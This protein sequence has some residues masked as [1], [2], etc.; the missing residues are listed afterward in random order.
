MM[1]DRLT[2]DTVL[3]QYPVNEG[4]GFNSLIDVLKMKMLRYPKEGGKAETLDIPADQAAKASVHAAHIEK[5]LKA[6][7]LLW[8]F[9]SQ[10]IL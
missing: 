3:I 4:V 10:M 2:N 6:M 7:K 8:N 9:S 5:Q 1:K